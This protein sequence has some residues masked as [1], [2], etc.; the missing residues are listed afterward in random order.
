MPNET[1][2]FSF[3]LLFCV[4]ILA[5]LASFYPLL[6][7]PC[8][9]LSWLGL[10]ALGAFGL[11]VHRGTRNIGPRRSCTHVHIRIDP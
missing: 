3:R 11:R 9:V 6:C 4:H 2:H 1:G 7:S 5:S 8:V 10:K